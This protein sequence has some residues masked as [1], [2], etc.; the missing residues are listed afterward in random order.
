MLPLILGISTIGYAM[1]RPPQTAAEAVFIA[2]LILIY[3]V[4]AYMAWRWDTLPQE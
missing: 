3:T 2:A 1:F 4:M